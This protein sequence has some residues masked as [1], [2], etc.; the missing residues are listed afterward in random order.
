M[1]R[2]AD[3][4][5]AWFNLRTLLAVLG[6]LLLLSPS[7]PAILNWLDQSLFTLG[8][9]LH[10]PPEPRLG[11]SLVEL[12]EDEVAFL[13][14][15]PGKAEKTFQLLDRVTGSDKIVVG[16]LL[17]EA[18]DRP[19]TAD[20]LLAGLLADG[21]SLSASLAEE[22]RNT[23]ESY[24]NVS[25]GLRRLQQHPQVLMAHSPASPHSPQVKH[26]ASAAGAYARWFL[27]WLRP[28]LEKVDTASLAGQ[29]LP[30][31]WQGDEEPR[32]GFILDLY[33]RLARAES[34]KWMEYTGV[35]VGAAWFPL[36][37]DGSIF[38][39][40]HAQPRERLSLDDALENRL[41]NNLILL[42][43]R[44]SPQLANVAN[45][46]RSFDNNSYYRT[47]FWF[48]SA[49]AILLLLVAFHLLVIIPRLSY[50]AGVL[51]SCLL[52]LILV[53]S[54]LGWQITQWQWLPMGVAVQFL[55][56]GHLL[57]MIWKR[58]HERSME[59]QAAAHG[60][61]YQL[62]LQLFR[63]GRADDALLAIKECF[64]TDAV[65][66]LMYDIAAQQE[67]K[68][69]YG[70]A[71]KTYRALTERRNNF[72]DAPQKVEKLMAF[73]SGAGTAI[74][75]ESEIT[76][77]LIISESS[78]NK[79]VLGRYEVERE[80]G[81]GA[82]GVVYLGRDPKIARYVAIKTLSYGQLD[83]DEMEEF[84][85]RFFREAEAAGRL[86]HPNIVTIYDVGEEHDL[87]FIAMDYV[88]GSPLNAFVHDDSRLP[89]KE[90]LR[91]MAEAADALEYAHG[92]KVVHRDIKPA[93]I[94]YSAESGHI[95]VTDFGVARLV[96][97]ARTN[98]GDV[99]GSPLYMSPEQMKGARVE[100]YTDIYSL[101]V[102]LF[103]L[104][105]GKLPF[106]G[107]NLANLTYNII[108]D[109]TPNIRQI[110]PDLPAGITRIVNR[111]LQKDPAKRFPN[112]AA[113]AEALRKLMD[114]V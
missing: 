112:A 34:V 21:E 28:A 90:V 99:L 89:V 20:S 55:L 102:T 91:I 18:P 3:T 76:K 47:P 85:Q 30:L 54:Q 61:R 87:A 92:K 107:E 71:L 44:N 41:S 15:D 31:L 59:W 74:T 43:P 27:P 93:N 16:L 45:A 33:A 26:E 81:R 39:Y 52:A 46:L 17:P 50:S 22:E 70:E 65:L 40:P 11:V 13:T 51:A 56:F 5:T 113:M 100:H 114:E 49:R 69:H 19:A 48:A 73:S 35:Q 72:R 111:A 103:Q 67:R 106:N 82:M 108:H 42:G 62:G 86:S 63:D 6:L 58:Q 79:P 1:K 37:F 60:A 98:T 80:L 4:L 12:P 14:R 38:P 68:R 66:G 53:V 10:N 64:T 7:S 101:G 88:K 9:K 24:L 109:K 25:G 29:P 78:I 104:L 110:R 84:K 94:L 32:A 75:G 36:S 77:T 83:P 95:K 23:L 57:M 8:I 2:A 96:D 105:S 97:S